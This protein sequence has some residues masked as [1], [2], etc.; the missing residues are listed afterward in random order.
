MIDR[1]WAERFADEWIAAWN[2]HDLDRVLAHY[3][4][5]IEMASPLITSIADEPSG[6][7]RG[8]DRVRAYWAT[9]LEGM[10]ELRFE[11]LTVFVGV[12]SITIHYRGPRGLGAES[13]H[14]DGG[15]AGAVDGAG[16]VAWAYAH[17]APNTPSA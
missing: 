7:V 16:K 4:D 11:L 17:Y 9:A 3:T 1:A 13:L 5:E 10:P 15:T 6:T 8:K 14:F 2:A 12:S